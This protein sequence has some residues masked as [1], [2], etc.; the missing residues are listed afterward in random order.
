MEHIK[1]I[2]FFDVFPFICRLTAVLLLL[3]A[4]YGMGVPPKSTIEP[5]K[6]ILIVFSIFFF[7]VPIAKKISLGKLLTFEREI[8]KVKTDVTEFKGETRQILSTYSSMITAISN[9]A[10]QTVNV[11]L[12]GRAEAQEAKE[13]LKSTLAEDD[14]QYDSDDQ[15]ELYM[16]Q[17]GGDINFAL[18][19]LRMDLERRLREI[20]GKRT[21]TSD[22][23]NMKGNFL[24]ARQLFSMF[25]E[26]HPRYKGM[27]SSFDYILKVCNAAIHGQQISDGHGI[28]ALGMGLK[29]LSEFE[30]ING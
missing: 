15:I 8:E 9:T 18:A 1:K 5:S 30:K 13:E 10:N 28:E 16:A 14:D 23:N 4:F 25:I 27:H 17:S 19:R 21:S 2:L 29:M 6:F 26:R 22:P 7:L 24:S 12:P 20:L 11:H 3:H